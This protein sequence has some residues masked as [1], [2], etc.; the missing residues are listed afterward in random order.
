[1]RSSVEPHTIA[2]ET[3]QKTNWKNHLDGRVASDALMAGK[4]AGLR[5]CRNAP[6]VPHSAPEPPNASANPIAQ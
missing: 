1:M 2:R 6:C 3:A 5:S 4:C